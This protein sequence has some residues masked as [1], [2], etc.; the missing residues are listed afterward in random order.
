MI[1]SKNESTATQSIN[2]LP[3]EFPLDR[4]VDEPTQLRYPPLDRPAA[5]QES[6][7][8]RPDYW[9]LPILEWTPDEVRD[10]IKILEAIYRKR[11]PA[12]QAEQPEAEQRFVDKFYL[13]PDNVIFEVRVPENM[14]TTPD[15]VKLY[16]SRLAAKAARTESPSRFHAAAL[17]IISHHT[18]KADVDEAFVDDLAR[19]LEMASALAFQDAVT[20]AR[21][22]TDYGGGH[23]NDGHM[24][25]FQHG[26]QTVITA[27]E[28]TA[29]NPHDSQVTA[30]RQIGTAQPP[31]A[32]DAD[33]NCAR[34]TA[35]GIPHIDTP[36]EQA[37]PNGFTW[38]YNGGRRIAL[39]NGPIDV[40]VAS[41]DSAESWLDISD[42]N[43]KI[44]ENAFNRRASVDPSALSSTECA[45]VFRQL[46]YDGC[47]EW[48]GKQGSG[49]YVYSKRGIQSKALGDAQ[50][51]AAYYL[52]H[53]LV[54]EEEQNA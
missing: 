40:L 29:K 49:G 17:A 53:G 48:V 16:A 50:I 10:R 20:V 19:E 5:V 11:L 21:G 32:P 13:S 54:R 24:E 23:H 26:I 44:I 12:E 4:T 52:E 45:R 6:K 28:A 27:L 39:S 3:D 25:A 31:I 41:G 42:E 7:Q 14:N 43:A 22:C 2:Q 9:K 18:A 47:D 33:D 36:S 30:L 46:K 51:I 8:L 1:V 15:G 34:L 37:A 35:E 38:E